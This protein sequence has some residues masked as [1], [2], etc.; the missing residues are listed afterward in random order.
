VSSLLIIV[1]ACLFAAAVPAWRA[2][3][4]DPMWSLRQE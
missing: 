4:V 3:K 2:A 1:A